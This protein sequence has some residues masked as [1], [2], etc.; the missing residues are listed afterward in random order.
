[1]KKVLFAAVALVAMLSAASCSK[2]DKCKCT[3]KAG[4]ATYEN[5]IYSRPED[6]KC[7]E[8]TTKDVSLGGLIKI[9][10]SGVATL[11]CQNYQ[12]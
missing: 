2:S 12:E 1:M 6:K 3:V 7:S 10:F 11:D 5:Q 8:L 4:D 9:D